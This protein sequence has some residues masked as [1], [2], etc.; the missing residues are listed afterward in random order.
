MGFGW[1]TSTGSAKYLPVKLV[2]GHY[3][4]YSSSV[5]GLV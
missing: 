1:A 4:N 2:V 5:N 3:V